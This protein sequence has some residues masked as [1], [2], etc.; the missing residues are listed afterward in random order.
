[1]DGC[2]LQVAAI[3]LFIPC[4]CADLFVRSEILDRISRNEPRQP[5]K[6]DS[7]DPFYCCDHVELHNFGCE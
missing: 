5:A 3:L 1:M 7:R 2:D 4:A 6:Q